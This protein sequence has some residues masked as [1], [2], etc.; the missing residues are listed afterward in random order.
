MKKNKSA[1]SNLASAK[2]SAPLLPSL[3]K[4][5]PRI[6]MSRQKK[7]LVY[8]TLALAF[9]MGLCFMEQEY[10]W[11]RVGGG[12][13]YHGG[14][15]SSSHRSSSFR[16]SSSRRHSSYRSHSTYHSSPHGSYSTNYEFHSSEE[17]EAFAVFVCAFIASCFAFVAFVWILILCSRFLKKGSSSPAYSYEFYWQSGNG[18]YNEINNDS[19]FNA[20][21]VRL[22][23]SEDANFSEPLFLDFVSGL[24][25]RIQNGRFDNF[26]GVDYYVS[27]SVKAT[28]RSNVP[29]GAQKIDNVIVGSI[30]ITDARVNTAAKKLQVTVNIEAN[31]RATNSSGRENIYLAKDR[32]T[33]SR[34]LGVLSQGPKE[35][36]SF[37]CPHCGS[38]A[39]L[40]NASG[41]CSHCG[42]R[43]KNGQ[44][45]WVLSDFKQLLTKNPPISVH[46]GSEDEYGATVPTVRSE[47]LPTAYRSLTQRH[48]NFNLQDFSN[49]VQYIFNNLQS[50]WSNDRWEDVRPY[51]TDYMFGNHSFWLDNYRAS[52]LRNKIE[53]IK[54]E[55]LEV[56]K[57][58]RD[59][60]YDIITVRFI[61]SAKDYTINLNTNRVVGGSD[62]KSK[63]FSEYW[64]FIRSSNFQEKAQRPDNNHCPN[65]GAKL[66]VAMSGVCAYCDTKITQ[67]TFDWTLCN[68]QQAE[69]YIG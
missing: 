68:I 12:H 32:L 54:I 15:S 48:P 11:G 69:A 3:K 33:L 46:L 16:S 17:G 22:L 25:T 2:L 65:C 50:A 26:S 6:Y 28:L 66:N 34:E 36:S 63:R 23:H 38:T 55:S 19:E 27:D 13:S 4:G 18:S 45:A 40:D 42:E 20:A 7:L 37:A 29:Y 39:G 47:N 56:V 67:G 24:Y 61:V 14:R 49:R 53:D 44:F 41:A 1:P 52:N 21:A 51:E 35:I 62:R 10:A 8:V 60:F 43:V 57:I 5:S 9:L 30:N 59:A 64:T 31:Y 58:S